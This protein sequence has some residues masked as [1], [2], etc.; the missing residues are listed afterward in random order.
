MNHHCQYHYTLVVNTALLV[1]CFGFGINNNLK[2][3]AE[4]EGGAPYQFTPADGK[5]GNSSRDHNG[6]G[7]ANYPNGDQYN[8]EYKDGTRQGHG[9]YVYANGDRYEG[10]FVEN[11]KHGIGRFTTKEKGE[12]YGK[13]FVR[14]GSGRTG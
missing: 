1:I 13:K 10:A 5:P 4:E 14:Q 12:Y 11:R 6:M 9:K 2:L 8:G 3:M 7:L